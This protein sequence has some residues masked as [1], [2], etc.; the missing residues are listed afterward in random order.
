MY[1]TN[2]PRRS[3]LLSDPFSA[4]VCLLT[5]GLR[6]TGPGPHRRCCHGRQRSNRAGRVDRREK[7]THR[8]RANCDINDSGSYIVSSSQTFAL[9]SHRIR[10]KPNRAR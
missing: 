6:P 10:A 3:Q 1:S 4:T 8:R 2:V 5:A 7:R 9:H